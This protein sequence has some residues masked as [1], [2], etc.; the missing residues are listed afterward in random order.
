MIK[1][2]WNFDDGDWIHVWSIFK[3][4]LKQF[5]VKCDWREVKDSWYFLKI[6]FCYDHK[7]IDMEEKE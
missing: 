5:F 3:N 4:M 7:R 6:H 2:I 1:R